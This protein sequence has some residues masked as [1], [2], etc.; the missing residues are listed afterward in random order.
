MVFFKLLNLCYLRRWALGLWC[1]LRVA[2]L[3]LFTCTWLYLSFL[4]F[5]LFITIFIFILNYVLIAT[6]CIF[7][8]YKIW[9]LSNIYC[10]IWN[11]SF[12]LQHVWKCFGMLWVNWCQLAV[13]KEGH[14]LHSSA[15]WS[16]LEGK[17][18][19]ITDWHTAGGSVSQLSQWTKLSP[20]LTLSTKDHS[21]I[22]MNDFGFYLIKSRLT[23][24]PVLPLDCHL[25]TQYTTLTITLQQWTNNK[26]NKSYKQLIYIY[27]YIMQM[28]HTPCR[29]FH[30]WCPCIKTRCLS[31]CIHNKIQFHIPGKLWLYVVSCPKGND[32]I[33]E[34][35]PNG[36][37]TKF[38]KI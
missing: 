2:G 30:P 3:V 33:Q 29:T 36:G 11:Y 19:M 21:D 27:I 9:I 34:L 4:L 18:P 23:N 15:W 1:R 26:T 17:F 28:W 12:Y 16:P 20:W 24:M 22:T 32:S 10:F 13:E 6:F 38:S 14:A 5:C 7:T 8:Y 25:P 35:M 37:N 31:W